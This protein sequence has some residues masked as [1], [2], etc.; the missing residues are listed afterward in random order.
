MY[1][2]KYISISA[3]FQDDGRPSMDIFLCQM[4]RNKLQVNHTYQSRIFGSFFFNSAPS[5]LV[6]I[7]PH[8]AKTPRNLGISGFSLLS[9][10]TN[11]NPRLYSKNRIKARNCDILQFLAFSQLVPNVPDMFHYLSMPLQGT[12]SVF[13]T[14]RSSDCPSRFMIVSSLQPWIVPSHCR[15]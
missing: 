13:M 6:L 12:I 15:I 2:S 8:I 9:D 10:H 11:V 5:K 14:H 1:C 3:L 4:T 7:A